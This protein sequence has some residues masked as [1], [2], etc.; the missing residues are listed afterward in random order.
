MGCTIAPTL[1]TAEFF[2]APGETDVC[3]IFGTSVA[4]GLKGG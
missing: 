3:P 1:P 2:G 4:L